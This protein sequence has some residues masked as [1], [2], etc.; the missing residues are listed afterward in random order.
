M[1]NRL[2]LHRLTAQYL[3]SEHSLAEADTPLHFSAANP[4]IYLTKATLRA[5]AERIA[6]YLRHYFDIGSQGPYKDVV[7]VCSSGQPAVPA[8]LYGVIG[9]GGVFSAASP[10]FTPEELARQIKQGKSRTLVISG[11]KIELG[12]KAAQLAGLPLD[13]VIILNSEPKWECKS[14]QGGKSVDVD[15][16]PTM[17]WRRV[18]DEEELKNSLIVLLYS[19][20]TTGVPKG[21]SGPKSA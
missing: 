8:I 21:E 18:T 14:L 4:D 7:V 5:L 11:D 20:G 3:D 15:N 16:G 12:K 1:L 2:K 13:R 17:T 19:S 9:A 6:H 10:S